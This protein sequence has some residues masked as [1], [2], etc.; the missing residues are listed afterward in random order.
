M[1]KSRKIKK[2]KRDSTYAWISLGLAL[3][4]WVPL[5]NVLIILPGSLY[6][7]VRAIQQSRK[8]PKKYGGLVLASIV[9]V[10]SSISFI[11]AAII[12]YMSVTGKV[13]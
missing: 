7:G 11:F 9:V 10:F 6:F 3:F 13:Q 4:F 1:K 8:E 2:E 12:L 5:L